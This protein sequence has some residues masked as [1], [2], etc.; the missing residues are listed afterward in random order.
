MDVRAR[1][2]PCLVLSFSI[3][4]RITYRHT[5]VHII[6]LRSGNTISHTGESCELRTLLSAVFFTLH[7]IS[8]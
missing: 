8:N 1:P 2:P 7:M 6:K 3:M 5:F 4:H